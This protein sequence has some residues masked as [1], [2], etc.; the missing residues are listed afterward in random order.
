MT[1]I[2]MLVIALVL[3]ALLGEPA[4]LW[5]RVPHPV[6]LAGQAVDWLDARLNRDGAQR[7][8]GVVAIFV[9]VVGAVIVGYILSWIPDF[10]ALEIL[11]AAI[12]LSHRSLVQHVSD[13]ASALRSSL[14]EGRD[15]VAG[16]VGRDPET[17]DVAGV[18]R[19]AIESAAENFSDG[20][21][22]PAFWFLLF[23]LPG[24]LVYKVV[25]TADS[26]IGHRSVR[27]I[28]FG[29]AAARLDDLLNWIPARLTGWLIALA[30]M[31]SGAV[32]CMKHD[33]DLHRSP[34]AGWPEAAMAG[35]LDIAL[36]GPRTYDG[37]VTDQPF[38]NATGRRELRY[39]D[40]N[41]A[42]RVLWK[43]WLVLLVGLL[44]WAVLIFLVF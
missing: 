19:A 34:N 1:H 14:Q 8:E 38:I 31:S 36:S 11:G 23:G 33:A 40:I 4:W 37:E 6:A 12:L 7:M 2:E 43:S 18:S 42:V 3:D 10:G 9:L 15:T 22:A 32:D 24:I 44:P 39:G 41:D 28:E 13:V 20:V 29:W 16:I 21:V 30:T 17:L 27:Y 25:N 5:N 26:M 35:A